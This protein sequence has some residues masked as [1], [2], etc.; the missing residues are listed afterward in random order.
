MGASVLRWV[1]VATGAGYI[2]QAMGGAHGEREGRR[3]A[4]EQDQSW[5]DVGCS[6]LSD[7]SGTF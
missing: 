4:A 2:H 7:L 5:S 6:C 3:E 1:S